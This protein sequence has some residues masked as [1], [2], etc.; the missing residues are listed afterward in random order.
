MA[1]IQKRPLSRSGVL[2]MD[3][4]SRVGFEC[5][6]PGHDFEQVRAFQAQVHLL[7]N[8]LNKFPD[9][10]ELSEWY[11]MQFEKWPSLADT[12]NIVDRA[13]PGHVSRT[14][15]YLGVKVEEELQI[16]DAKKNQ[17]GWM[18]EVQRMP[19]VPMRNEPKKDPKGSNKK[20]K[21][22]VIVSKPKADVKRK[23]KKNKKTKGNQKDDPA[24]SFLVHPASVSATDDVKSTIAALK[25]EDNKYK[26]QAEVARLTLDGG[27]AGATKPKT[28][29]VMPSIIL[30][31]IV[32]F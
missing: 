9:P 8:S 20:Q 19:N 10:S 21:V 15:G 22:K 6:P 31:R 16:H 3:G 29:K 2:A 27:T 25:S 14:I 12:I 24:G 32:L 26:Q 13:R 28:P 4:R 11:L 1:K 23:A 30:K 18:Q 7:T 5:T 17:T